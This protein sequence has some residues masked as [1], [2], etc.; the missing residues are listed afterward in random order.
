MVDPDKGDDDIQSAKAFAVKAVVLGAI[1][2]PFFLAALHV[3]ALEL[4][5]D[6]TMVKEGELLLACISVL[7]VVATWAFKK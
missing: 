6:F 3:L 4:K 1:A 5:V 2:L 7:V